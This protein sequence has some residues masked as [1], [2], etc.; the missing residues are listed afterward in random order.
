MCLIIVSVLISLFLLYQ[1]CAGTAAGLASVLGLA[2]VDVRMARIVRHA[3]G[4]RGKVSETSRRQAIF[5]MV[6]MMVYKL[7]FIAM[8]S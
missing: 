2:S 7:L 6:I 3:A 5:T 1:P 8:R 4:F